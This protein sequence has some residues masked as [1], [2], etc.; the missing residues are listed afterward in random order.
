MKKL[1]LTVVALA[2]VTT[3]S[4]QAKLVS[5]KIGALKSESAIRIE[6]SY[7]N[8]SIGDGKKSEADYIK[9]KKE[10]YN[11]KEAGRGD[12]WAAAWID[13]R[14]NRFEPK[15]ITL[16]EKYSKLKTSNDA[17]YTMIVHTTRTEPGWNVAAPI[18][19]SARI[20]ADVLIVETAN[21]NNI[22][23]KIEVKD[24][25]GSGGMGMDY[26]TGLRIQEAYAKAGK[27]VGRILEK[28]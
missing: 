15:F 19:K 24:S 13:D 10:S 20:D 11:Q 5:G 27:E 21:K 12:K 3:V 17:K 28:R 7:D 14:E 2:A 1:F 18:R 23:A 26:D 16:F 4:A 6:F 8:M 9:E 22:I 25:P